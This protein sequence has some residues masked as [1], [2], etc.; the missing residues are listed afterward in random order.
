MQ[1]AADAAVK[2]AVEPA[3]EFVG[4]TRVRL[5]KLVPMAKYVASDG[6]LSNAIFKTTGIFWPQATRRK[7]PPSLLHASAETTD[8][9]KAR[10]A[11]AEAVR[12]WGMQID[13]P[14][15]V[16]NDAE[17]T[18]REAQLALAIQLYADGRVDYA[19]ARQ[20]AKVR[21]RVLDQALAA[22]NLSVVIYPLVI[23]WQQRQAG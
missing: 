4:K 1:T 7:N 19:Q 20:I 18:L 14:D 22:R 17:I 6:L 11:S 12:E 15:N 10:T 16:V 21:A 13:L 2:F 8:N 23:P 9:I 3:G 5:Y